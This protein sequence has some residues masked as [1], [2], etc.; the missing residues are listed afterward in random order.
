MCELAATARSLRE[1]RNA[2]QNFLILWALEQMTTDAAVMARMAADVR[3]QADRAL[4]D[5][6]DRDWSLLYRGSVLDD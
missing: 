3:T 4:A 2:Y 1:A 6:M 5:P